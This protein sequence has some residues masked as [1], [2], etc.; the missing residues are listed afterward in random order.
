VGPVASRAEAIRE[1]QAAFLQVLRIAVV[2]FARGSSPTLAV[3]YSPPLDSF[4]DWPAFVDMEG[5]K[6]L[7]QVPSVPRPTPAE[8]HEAVA[9][10]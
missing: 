5:V 7:A 10:I 4:R 2:A 1:Q 8:N 6:R 9:G 3:E